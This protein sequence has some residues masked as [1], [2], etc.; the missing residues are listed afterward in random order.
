MFIIATFVFPKL[1]F[2][3]FEFWF[4]GLFA[5]TRLD[6][7]LGHLYAQLMDIN[8]QITGNAASASVSGTSTCSSGSSSLIGGSGGG[9]TGMVV[10]SS[11]GQLVIKTSDSSVL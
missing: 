3:S 5:L 10:S 9:A 11:R 2:I 8:V 7:D 6:V 4:P 1:S